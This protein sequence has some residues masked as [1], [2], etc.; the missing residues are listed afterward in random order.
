MNNGNKLH[1][2]EASDDHSRR[3]KGEYRLVL[4]N[5]DFNEFTY[6][7]ETLI[8]VCNHDNIQAEQCTYLAHYH[9]RCEVKSGLYE[10]LKSMKESLIERGLQAEIQ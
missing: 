8:E 1:R 5:D 4:Y 7:I 6:V 10:K 2:H 9:G 3:D